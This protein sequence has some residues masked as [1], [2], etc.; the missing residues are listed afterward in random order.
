MTFWGYH[1]MLDCSGLQI[2]EK[3]MNDKE[4]LK[5]FV[6]EMLA[7]TNMQAW[8]PPL[9]ERLEEKDGVFPDSLSGY[10]VV[11]L[12]HTSNM[13]LHLCDKVRT[14]YFDLFSC[15]QFSIEKATDVVKKYFVPESV[16]TNYLT[17]QA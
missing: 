4:Y 1:L 7:E 10:T 13:C 9:I 2:D 16:R 17:R 12:L 5:E 8:G 14:L 15:K 6:S 3:H 11:Q